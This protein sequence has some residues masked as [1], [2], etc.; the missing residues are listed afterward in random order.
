MNAHGISVFYGAFDQDVA[1]AEVR[2]PVGSQA[3]VGKFALMRDVRILDVTALQ[4]LFVEGSTF[5]PNYADRLSLA[6]FMGRLSDR[7]TIP[8]MPDDE[9]TE[10]LI[11][12]MI[13]DYLARRPTPGLDGIMFKSVQRPADDVEP[14][15]DGSET[16]VPDLRNV[17]LFHHASRVEELELP[18]G[19][20]LSVNKYWST[21]DGDEPDYTVYE[22]VP[23]EPEAIDDAKP[24]D[25][26]GLDHFAAL[27]P[28]ALVFDPSADG[29]EPH[30][31][32]AKDSLVVRHVK[33]VSFSTDDFDVRRH[34]MERRDSK[35]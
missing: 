20:E 5:D 30:L 22:E 26:F 17:V 21:E 4:S 34:R 14:K 19:T 13:A 32:I 25:D 28:H 11:T 29:R 1:L 3:V 15:E 7:I 35:F 27:R 23:P 18:E 10:Y 16:P 33:G 31:R 9:P 24:A 2:P 6:K 12:Q 8:V